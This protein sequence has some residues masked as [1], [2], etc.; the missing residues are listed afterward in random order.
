LFVEHAGR[1]ARDQGHRPEIYFGETT[2][3]YVY[4]KTKQQEFD[5]P[6]GDT[7]ATT[8]IRA[9]A[10][11]RLEIVCD[12]CCS[13]GHRRSL[14]AAVLERVT[15]DSRV[16]INRNIREIVN[17]VA[18]FLT[19]DKDATSSFQRG[20][21]FWMID[22]LPSRLTFLIRRIT[23][24]PATRSTTSQQRQSRD[25]CLQ[26]DANVYV[27]DNKDPIIAATHV[28]P[29][30]LR[31]A[32]QCRRICEP[33]SFSG[34]VSAAAGCSLRALSHA[35]SRRYF[36]SARTFGVCATDHVNDEG[37]KESEPIDSYYVLMQLR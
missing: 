6:Q 21:L 24:L 5:Y 7:N 9:R 28:F 2:D 8:R 37:K 15:S 10:A 20:R 25:R 23:T 13:H 4:V 34:N 33:R 36:S 22:A 32:S 27:F 1:S 19:Y 30:L 35:E 26:R 17:G 12:A 29:N 11:Y 14:E 31:D 16:L 3:R 18:P